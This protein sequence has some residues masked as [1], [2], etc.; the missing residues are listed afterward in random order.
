MS[1]SPTG[2]PAAVS[3]PPIPAQGITVE[4]SF[5]TVAAFDQ[6]LAVA[7]KHPTCREFGEGK[8]LR[9]RATYQ[10]SELDALQELKEAA[11]ELRQKRT[12]LDAH[13]IPWH[14]MA[15]LTHCFREYLHRPR[16]EHCFF[17]GNFWSW[18]GCKYAVSN[19]SDRIN[20]EWLTFGQLDSDGVWVLDKARI[21]EYVR[22]KIYS[23][24]HRCPAFDEEYLNLLLE[25][26]PERIDPVADDR[27]RHVRNRQG[28]IVYVAPKD[29]GSAKKI[30]LEM[31]ERIRQQRGPDK[32]QE[33]GKRAVPEDYFR[34]YR[35][36]GGKKKGPLAKIF[37]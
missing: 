18:W 27:W 30:A 20:V 7:R 31:Q 29:V 25:S 35:G 26:F 36:T 13:E 17:D 8:A 33:N 19:L 32:V 23:S 24:F 16:R 9:V 15:Q 12:W 1:E 4:L 14:E 22:G 34:P 6:A 37:G 5:A 10:F 21:A 2:Q 28:E 3:E 11:W